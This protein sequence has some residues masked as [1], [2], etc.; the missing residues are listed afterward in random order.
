MYNRIIKILQKMLKQLKHVPCMLYTCS[1]C[2]TVPHPNEYVIFPKQGL[3]RVTMLMYY[4]GCNKHNTISIKFINSTPKSNPK[5]MSPKR[6]P[7]FF[8]HGL[9][10]WPRRRISLRSR[11][12]KH[13]LT[14]KN[15]SQLLIMVKRIRQLSK[16]SPSY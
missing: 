13:Q 8:F 14:I 16:S 3:F 11:Y 2:Y 15:I 7:S 6:H 9:S 10:M 4:L 1:L 5:F 12:P